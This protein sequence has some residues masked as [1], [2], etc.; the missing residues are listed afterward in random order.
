MFFYVIAALG[1]LYVVSKERSV[2]TTPTP[3]PSSS[4]GL[5]WTPPVAFAP[6]RVKFRDTSVT[7]FPI[8]MYEWPTPPTKYVLILASDDPTSFVGITTA[9]QHVPIILGPGPLTQAIL[10]QL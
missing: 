4:P 10:H 6:T 7:P 1:L 8:D 3:S 2:L 9:N 5:P